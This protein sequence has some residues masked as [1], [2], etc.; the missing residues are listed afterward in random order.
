MQSVAF[1]QLR[2]EHFGRAHEIVVAATHWLNARGVR[3]WDTPIPPE[4]YRERHDAGLNYGLFD[5]GDLVA[6]M[7]LK[8]EVPAYWQPVR[9]FRTPFRWLSTLAI[10]RAHA[11]GGLGRKALLGAE[12]HL[13]NAGIPLIYLDC[14]DR[15]GALPRFYSGAGFT[16]LERREWPDWTM[17]LF[18]KDL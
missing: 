18:S 1:A 15:G 2:S 4:T 14:V 5:N 12:D 16:M 7:T 11:G 6:V 17:C 13:R 10:D 8:E 9:E 3:Q